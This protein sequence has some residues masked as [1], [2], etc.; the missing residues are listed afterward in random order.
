MV[1]GAGWL[2]GQG[3]REATEWHQ[4]TAPTALLLL[5]LVLVAM[6]KGLLGPS[7]QLAVSGGL[8]KEAGIGWPPVWGGRE[9][10]SY[11]QTALL[12]LLLVRVV[13]CEG[14]TA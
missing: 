2:A 8:G 10:V 6:C 1:Q 12:L 9:G 4:Q 14:V 3:G 13:M 11:L 5:L 7:R